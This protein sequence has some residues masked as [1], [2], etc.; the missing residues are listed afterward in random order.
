MVYGTHAV[1]DWNYVSDPCSDCDNY[2][3]EEMPLSYKDVVLSNM[4]IQSSMSTITNE[5]TNI[6]TGDQ[7]QTTT[8]IDEAPNVIH[9][10]PEIIDESLY[11]GY[12]P[13]IELQKFLERPVLIHSCDW[14]ENSLLGVQ[15]ISPWH[16]YFNTTAIKNKLANFAY[17]SCNLRLKIMINAS[18]FYYGIAF[19]AYQPFS[20]FNPGRLEDSL[21][22]VGP[23]VAATCRDRVDILPSKNQAG[24]LLL[25][26]INIRNW[27]RVG[28]ASDFTSMGK[29]DIWSVH[30]LYNASSALGQKVTIQVF[31]WAENVKVSGATCLTPLQ[32]GTVSAVATAASKFS[33]T[34]A[35]K[36]PI[37]KPYA[38]AGEIGLGA[39][40]QISEIFGFSD[41]PV[42]EDVKPFKNLPFHALSSSEISTLYE[43]LTLDPKNELT[44]DNRISGG[45]GSDELS[46]PYL[47]SKKNI[48][49]LKSWAATA[50]AGNVVNTINV[51]PRLMF[52]YDGAIETTNVALYTTPLTIVSQQFK[53]WRGTMCYRFKFICTP[54]HRGRILMYWDPQDGTEANYST[55]TNY[56]T[57]VDIS[58]TNEI[59]IKV[60]F[61]QPVPYLNVDTG[62]VM[63]VTPSTGAAISSFNKENHNGRL[64]M[65]VLTPQTSPVDSAPILVYADVWMEDATFANPVPYQMAN[66]EYSYLPVQS[67]STALDGDEQTVLEENIARVN[68]QESPHLARIYCGERVNSIRALARRSTYYRSYTF[69]TNTTATWWV[70]YGGFARRPYY[71]GYDIN[72]YNT[73]VSLLGGAN[74]KY[75]YVIDPIINRF[76]PCFVG[77][78]GS[79]N[80][81]FNVR[82]HLGNSHFIDSLVARRIAHAVAATD[83]IYTDTATS[84]S[85]NYLDRYE[86]ISGSTSNSGGYSLTNQKTQTGLQVA[87]PMYSR[88]RFLSTLP[89]TARLGSSTDE[90]N[91]DN[92]GFV[93]KLKPTGGFD[94]VNMVVDMYVQIGQDYQ[95][96]HFVNVPTMW[97]YSSNPLPV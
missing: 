38:T 25:P 72:G 34:I 14:T 20:T 29:L 82:T 93:I 90:S 15:N 33:G 16:L 81:N 2:Y 80:Y 46:I 19:A 18:P 89:T 51:S 11:D 45:D 40:A 49:P 59:V 9:E 10:A 57:I 66:A 61:M 26:Y 74:K 44:V 1:D 3:S 47:C 30:P 17:L 78:R 41:E 75:N 52:T 27:L 21:E 79:F 54:Y 58:V 94:P 7:Q 88:F 70:T 76:R 12:T 37:L 4:P 35:K 64:S 48:V 23:T 68:V 22:F 53:F 87:V 36:I 85:L 31:A 55:A 60:P 91:V 63:N 5:N 6:D 43:K 84:T 95:L 96:L 50:V 39:L 69:A 32:A 83:D 71:H 56:N 67:A 65:K 42:I 28:L 13:N 73:A 92:L 77:D 86:Y 8:F 97:K 62:P 24:E